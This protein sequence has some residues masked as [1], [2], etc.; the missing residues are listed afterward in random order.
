MT[1]QEFHCQTNLQNYKFTQT[2]CTL[3]HNLPNFLLTLNSHSSLSAIKGDTEVPTH[4][5]SII[6]EVCQ[7]D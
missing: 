7:L 5:Q 4:L 1:M 3:W 2:D 6:H